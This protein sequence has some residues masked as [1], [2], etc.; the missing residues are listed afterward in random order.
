MPV[1]KNANWLPDTCSN[2]HGSRKCE[3]FVVSGCFVV[4]S[5][6]VELLVIP[7][8]WLLVV[9]GISNVGFS[10]VLIV[11]GLFVVVGGL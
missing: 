3:L 2:P 11:S 4:D 10:V 9:R 6:F 5:L 1:E 8:K 7:A